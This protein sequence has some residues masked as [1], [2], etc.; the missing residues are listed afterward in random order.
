[1]R[2]CSACCCCAPSCRGAILSSA[3]GAVIDI[4]IRSD[5]RQVA[6]TFTGDIQARMRPAIVT[7]LNRAAVSTR[8]EAVREIRATYNLRARTVRD[9]IRLKRATRAVLTALLTA[10]GKRVP[11]I[12][13]NPRPSAPGKAGRRSLGVSVLVRRDTGRKLVRHAFVQRMKS[14]HVGV[15]MRVQPGDKNNPVYRS[16][17]IRHGGSD[18]PIAEL[19]SLSLPAAFVNKSIQSVLAKTARARFSVE[20]ARALSSIERQALARAGVING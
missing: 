4:D 13:F 18:L 16:K 10:S 15:F 1:M 7:A 8:A 17:R 9:Q 5:L 3:S 6:A 12:E 14:G 11:L 2:W 20:F 19:T